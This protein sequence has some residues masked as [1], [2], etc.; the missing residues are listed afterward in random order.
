MANTILTIEHIVSDPDIRFGKPHIAGTRL[1]VQDIVIAHLINDSSLDWV[2][3]QFDLT[4]GQIYAALSYYYDHRAEIDE[5]VRRAFEVDEELLQASNQ[6][7]EQIR[8]RSKNVSK[9]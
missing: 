9:N 5:S 6:K 2:M 7:R 8:A 1:C 4:L 3:E